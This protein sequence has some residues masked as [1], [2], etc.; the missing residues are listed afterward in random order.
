MDKN[1]KKGTGAEAGGETKAGDPQVRLLLFVVLGISLVVPVA[2]SVFTVKTINQNVNTLKPTPVPGAEG[3]REGEHNAPSMVFY[4]P[5]E[6]LVNLADAEE[7]HYLRTTISLG[8]V[9]EVPEGVKS[10]GGGGHGGG[11]GGGKAES[12]LV[13]F[14]KPQEPVIRDTIISVISSRKFKDLGTVQGKNE[15]KDTLRM[16]L[17]EQLKLNNVEV[18]FTAF[19]LQ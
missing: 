13:G 8:L 10:G 1:D 16:R 7:S 9:G 14:I 17:K 11:H 19:T 12:P 4:D 2:T 6:F 15:L 5:L 3:E 18:Y